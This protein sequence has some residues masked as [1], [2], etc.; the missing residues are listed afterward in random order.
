MKQITLGISEFTKGLMLVNSNSLHIPL[1]DESVHCVVTSPPY[2]GL[3][4]YG[5]A[6]WEGGDAECDHIKSVRS[7]D[8]GLR[9]DGRAHVGLYD[10]EKLADLRKTEFKDVCG[11]CG[12]IRVDEQ[13]GLEQTPMEYVETMVRVFR[14][15]KR[16]LRRDGTVWLNIG[17]SFSSGIIESEEYVLREDL[18]DEEL[19]YVYSELAKHLKK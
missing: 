13:I 15:I 10:G 3:R 5:T 9:N 19:E 12:A 2:Y 7:N 14:E 18:T 11:K 1:A 6:R 8:S 16:V 17:S 4:D